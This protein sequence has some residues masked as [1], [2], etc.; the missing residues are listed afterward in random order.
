MNNKLSYVSEDEEVGDTGMGA[1]IFCAATNCAFCAGM[2][3]QY[4]NSCSRNGTPSNAWDTVI[5]PAVS[6]NASSP[7]IGLHFATKICLSAQCLLHVNC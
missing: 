1:F 6:D 5:T 7:D 3:L 2:I 4:L